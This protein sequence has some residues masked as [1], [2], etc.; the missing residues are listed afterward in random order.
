[1]GKRVLAATV[2]ATLGVGAK[3]LFRQP[4]P[5][6]IKETYKKICPERKYYCSECKLEF[7]ERTY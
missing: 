1:M 7:S 2:S 3:V 4:N 5:I 6:I